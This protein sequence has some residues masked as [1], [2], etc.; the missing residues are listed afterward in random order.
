MDYIHA[1]EV[2][3]NSSIE[4]SSHNDKSRTWERFIAWLETVGWDNDPF[5][6]RLTRAKKTRM[7]GAFVISLRRGEHSH[8]RHKG[9]LVA[10]TISKALSNLAATFQDNNHSDLRHNIDGKTDRFISG[11]L[12]SF[13]K[14]DPK[15]KAQKAI[16]P[17]LLRHLYTRSKTTFFQHVADL[18][19]GAFFF[20][21]RSCEYSQTTGS[22]KT[23]ILTPR[24]IV[25]RQG[26][27]TIT[28]RQQF[29][30][31]NSVSITFVA[32]KND[33]YH[34]TVTQHATSN[35]DLCPVHIWSKT[36]N[37]VLDLPK[38]T[39]DTHVNAFWNTGR[40]RTEFITSSQILESLRW[41]AGDLGKNKLGYTKDEIGCHSIRSGAAM[42]MYLAQYP[43][44][45]PT[46]TIMLQGRWC[47][48]AF[49]RY[50]RKQV[51]ESS[52]GVSEAM[53]S[54]E[55]YDFFTIADPVDDTTLEDPRL[56]N[57]PQ[58]L[59][60]SFTGA[61]GPRFTRNHIFE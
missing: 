30:T 20:A 55:S 59:T 47:S 16:T 41:A 56:P 25:F 13:K 3:N 2:A 7:A 53:I 31:A 44:R 61:A 1:A 50:I 37:R 34:D 19:T 38:A 4:E 58:S 42:A 35:P 24:N 22:R 26:N 48:D 39:M 40:K 11:I 60:S 33:M 43:I 49:L 36:V 27:R 28:N 17:A 18:C 10:G 23:K 57:N 54:K 51:K 12:R 46:Y 6:T 14:V 45:V 52:K 8:E 5:L 15:E 9:P 29:S 32:Q 21:C